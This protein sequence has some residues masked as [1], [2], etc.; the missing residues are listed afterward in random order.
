[1]N[2][3]QTSKTALPAQRAHLEREGFLSPSDP[4][5]ALA[6]YYALYHDPA[7]TQLWL[8]FDAARRVDG[9]AAVCQ[10]GFNLF[11]PT[12]VLRAADVE[13]AVSLLRLALHPG[14][15]YY[16]VTTPALAPALPV[17]V[18]L[19]Q[20]QVNHIYLFDP[21][22]RR[23]EI[24]VLLQPA[25]SA[26]GSPRFVIRSQGQVAAEAGVNWRS[27]YFAEMFVYTQPQARGRGW[28]RT[29]A[30]ACA[31][32]L[33]QLGVQPLYAVGQD[34]QASLS[35]A[36]AAG[37]VDSGAREFAGQGVCYDQEEQAPG[38]A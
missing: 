28:G 35:L 12:V 4:G 32:A 19:E 26:D 27:P 37:F 21:R 10:T 31:V 33:H 7:R 3:T 38:R 18:R 8:H 23:P 15:P 17:L 29:V 24:N 9:L 6:L 14:R 36:G 25:R 20:E 13:V 2:T 5:D 11:Q 1:M 34:N 16:V 30:A 22:R